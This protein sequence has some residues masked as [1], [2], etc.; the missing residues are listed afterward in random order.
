[1][2][3]PE[4]QRKLTTILCADVVGYNEKGEVFCH[5]PLTGQRREMA[6]SGFEAKRGCL[7]FRCPA[8]AY[9]L[10]CAGRAECAKAAGVQPG[11]Y[12]RIVRIPLENDRRIFTPLARSSHAWKTQY[13]KRTAAERIDSRIDRVYGF[14]EHFIRG[15][16]KMTFR[17]GLALAA[18]LAVALGHLKEQRRDYIRSLVRAYHPP[19]RRAG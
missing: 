11:S 5:C 1:M 2:A 19:E 12:G 13:A 15:K 3:T 7:K 14:E 6:F 8:A 9:D 10:E 4:I 16:D 17:V 18:M